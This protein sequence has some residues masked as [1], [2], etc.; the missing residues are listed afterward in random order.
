VAVQEGGA[1]PARQID[2]N[3]FTSLSFVDP[4]LFLR[5]MKDVTRAQIDPDEVQWPLKYVCRMTR[6]A[7][8][9]S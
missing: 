8:F 7:E 5:R 3:L 9:K 6:T 2:T 4:R 1:R